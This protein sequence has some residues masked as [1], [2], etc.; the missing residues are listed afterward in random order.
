[1]KSYRPEELFNAAGKLK[2]E[3]AAAGSEGEA[4]HERQSTRQRRI[5]LLEDLQMPDYR[6]M[7]S[8]VHSPGA[9]T[10]KR[11]AKW[12]NSSATSCGSTLPNQNFRVVQSGRKQLESLAGC[13]GSDESGSGW[14]S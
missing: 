2:P 10:L 9:W 7:P 13:S 6:N 14:Q 4:A 3:I 11:L 5:L 1:M 12:G 8:K